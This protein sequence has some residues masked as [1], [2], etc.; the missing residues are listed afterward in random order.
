MSQTLP[1]PKPV[2]DA[3]VLVHLAR[4]SQDV[5]SRCVTL[6]L[7]ATRATTVLALLHRPCREE[8]EVVAAAGHLAEQAV[9]R[10]FRWGEALAWRVFV[11]GEA[12]LA[13]DAHT[14]ADAHFISGQA[15]PGMYLGVPLTDPD[16]QVIGVLSIDTTDSAETLGDGDAQTLTLLGQAAGVAYARWLAL[17]RAQ[18]TAHRFE[19]LARLSA[20][21]ESLQTPDEIARRALETLLDLSGFTTGAVFERCGESQVALTVLAGHLGEGD[22][23]AVRL[24]QPHAPTGL[25]AQVLDTQSTLVVPDYPRWCQASPV[26][27]NQIHTALAAP[28][29]S[30]GR[31][32]GVIGLAHLGQVHE[33][34]PETVTLLEMVAAH[35]DRAT[36]R[37]A[38]VEH[39]RRMREAALRG[40]GRVLERRDGETFGHTDRVTGLA[41]RLGE[42]LGLSPAALQHLR[43]GAYLHDVGKVAVD[44]QI[45]RKPG[46]LTPAEREAM[47]AHVVVG[48]DMLRDE[49]FVPREVRQVVRSHHERWDGAGYPDGLA[50]E[51]I[52]LLARIFSVVDVYDALISPRPYKPAWPAEAA[53][54]E[55]ARGA[56]RQFD[57]RVVQAFLGLPS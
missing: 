51:D 25:V 28:L 3:H 8:L 5:F 50:G 33:V 9:G 6:A 16:G 48:D 42:A 32:G 22:L 29:R 18:Q 17:E 19:Q 38:G 15:R 23:N 11:A 21:L 41:V 39:L 4:S 55:L 31:V 36:E 1:T 34:S 13:P 27:V 56:G 43:W 26:A 54:A 20:E 45:L 37:A 53:R 12:Y 40:V 49:A 30:R 14:R 57:P 47:Q 44:D 52:P 10:T 35:I 2:L 7:E 24:H 46:P